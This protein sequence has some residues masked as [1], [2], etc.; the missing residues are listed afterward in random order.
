MQVKYQEIIEDIFALVD[1]QTGE[2]VVKTTIQRI[3]IEV[4]MELVLHQSG[5]ARN[6]DDIV[7]ILRPQ[8]GLTRCDL[9]CQQKKRFECPQFIVMFI[10]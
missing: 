9:G 7:R 3:I 6:D 4:V 1:P 8:G 5:M 10:L 2:T